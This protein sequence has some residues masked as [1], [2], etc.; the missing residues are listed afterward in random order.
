MPFRLF[1]LQLC[2]IPLATAGIATAS[3]Q[4][5]SADLSV[6]K[7]WLH[8]H[9]GLRTLQ[10]DF[11]Q[12]RQMRTLKLPVKKSGKLWLDLKSKH[13]RWQTG[14][15]PSVIVLNDGKRLTIVQ[16]G[17]KRV[18]Y[19]TAGMKGASS[20]APPGL[21]AL[22]SGFPKTLDEFQKQNR[23]LSNERDGDI[24]KLKTVPIQGEAAKG[25]REFT[26]RIDAEEHYLRGF[27]I[28]LKDGSKVSSSFRRIV[29]NGTIPKEI[30]TVDTEGYREE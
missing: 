24:F 2:L 19:R 30:F 23:I 21:S 6:V 14:D 5:S 9:A 1:L 8:S 18:E 10:I 16:P 27:E 3:G 11:D 28:V 25:I 22:A 29:T 26:Y 7:K 13:F 15:P 4:D 17:R 20:D 12:Q